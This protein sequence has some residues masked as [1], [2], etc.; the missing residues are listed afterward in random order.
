MRMNE[1]IRRHSLL[2]L[3]AALAMILVAC[4]GDDTTDDDTADEDTAADESD[5]DAEADPADEADDAADDDAGS[6]DSDDGETVADGVSVTQVAVAAPEEPTDFGWNQAG[7]EGAERAADEAGVEIEIAGGLGYEAPVSTLRQLAEESQLVFAHASGY[8]VAAKEVAEETGVPMI[9]YD[10]PDSREE[11][12]AAFVEVDAYEG[13][14]LAGIVAANMTQTDTLGIVVSATSDFNWAM[15]S[16]GYIAGARSV[17]PDIEFLAASIGE[18]AYADVEGGT[19]VTESVIAGGADVILGNGDGSAFGM[20]RAIENADDVWYI[21]VI[22]DKREV[23][24]GN[25]LLTGIFWDFG[26]VY[27]EAI[28]DVEAGTFGE[29]NYAMNLENE[30][31]Q[32]LQTEYIPDDVWAQVE[33]ARDAIIAGEID[34]PAPRT[35]AEVEAQIEEG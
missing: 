2:P 6:D 29:R 7:I 25:I 33:E 22:G 21:D 31:V 13:G 9:V 3:L 16:G 4:G 17:N 32:L 27:Y 26:A 15:H 30:G 11:G 23:D 1:W 35:F 14:Y 8:G 24:E 10:S 20:M 28:Q 5:D 19:R 12:V 34:I 18:A